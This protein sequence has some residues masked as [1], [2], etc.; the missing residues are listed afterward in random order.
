MNFRITTISVLVAGTLLAG[1]A[2]M[3]EQQQTTAKGA[4]I[5]ALAGAAVGAMVGGGRGAATGAALGA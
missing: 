1:C 5:G 3:T 2:N 4:G